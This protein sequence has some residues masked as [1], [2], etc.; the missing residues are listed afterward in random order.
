MKKLMVV[1]A[2]VSTTVPLDLEKQNLGTQSDVDAT[3]N[4][5]I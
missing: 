4:S 3:A 5:K 2:M 1:A